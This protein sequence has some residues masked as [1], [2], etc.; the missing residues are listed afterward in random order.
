[1]AFQLTQLLGG[2]GFSN[3]SLASESQY[4]R[5][6]AGK[7]VASEVK[8]L[9]AANPTH[10]KDLDEE[11]A[12][13]DVQNDFLVQSTRPRHRVGLLRSHFGETEREFYS[14]RC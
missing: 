4:S 5:S 3:S 6:A 1:M 11:C 10:I 13:V 7:L 14:C 12:A 2:Y 9:P 8:S